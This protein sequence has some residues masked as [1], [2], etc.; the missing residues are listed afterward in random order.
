[1]GE[2]TLGPLKAS[3]SKAGQRTGLPKNEPKRTAHLLT[4]PPGEPLPSH[5]FLKI[6]TVR[7]RSHGQT[8]VA[9]V[10]PIFA[11]FVFRVS[12]DRSLSSS[13]FPKP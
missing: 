6:E 13:L 12:Y 8:S 9:G 10:A 5:L 3:L 1:M 4:W 2:L 7:L 11:R